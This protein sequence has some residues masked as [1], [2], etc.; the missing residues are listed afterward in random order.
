MDNL[1]SHCRKSLTDQLGAH[2]GNQL[3]NRLQVD[4]TPTHGSWLKHAELELSLVARQCQGTRRIAGLA[5]L[6][7]DTRA[8]HRRANRP[9]V[10]IRWH[11]TRQAARS[12]FSYVQNLSR[13]SKT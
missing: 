4:Y 2:Q 3:G 9:Q 8:W 6:K 12:K 1:T 5:R 13:R 11:F 7:A 10:Q